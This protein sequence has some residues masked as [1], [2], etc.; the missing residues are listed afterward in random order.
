MVTIFALRKAGLALA[1]FLSASALCAGHRRGVNVSIDDGQDPSRCEDIRITI[2]ENPVV[3]AQESI[4]IPETPGATLRVRVP[5]HSGVRVVGGDRRDFEVVVCKAAPSSQDLSRIQVTQD[6]G[7]LSVRGPGGSGWVAYLLIAAPRQASLEL[8]AGNAPIA[9]RGLSGRV[10]VR[11]VNGPI[12]L[13]DCPGEIEAETENGPLHVSAAGGN[14]RLRTSNGPI[15]VSLSGTVWSGGEL[16]ASAVNGPV[17]LR[18]PA[19]YRSGAVVE[20]L[21]HGPFQCRGE[22]CSE[23]RRTWDDRNKRLELGEGPTLVRVSTRN[24]P[25]SVRSSRSGKDDADED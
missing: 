15:G 16:D 2:D 23:A 7:E 20:S 11:T 8:D 4:R 19:G 5:D 13:K 24:G 14:L 9:L 21:G 12:S 6:A 10:T 3:R 18:I 1:L 17:D 22:I 25:V